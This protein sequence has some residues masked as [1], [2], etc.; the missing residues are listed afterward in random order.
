MSRLPP[1]RKA[2]LEGGMHS[3]KNLAECLAIDQAALAR[4]VLPD[5]GLEAALPDVLARLNEVAAKGISHQIAAIGMAI[6]IALQ[7][8]KKAA[9]RLT[10]QRLSN[11]PSDTVRSWAAFALTR[12]DPTIALSDRLAMARPFAA[13]THFGVR[14]W[15]W[16][17]VRPYIA[18]EIVPAVMLLQGWTAS[19]NPNIRRFAV[20]STRPRGVWG[21]HIG[22]LKTDP[23]MALPLL[24]ALKADTAR[25]VQDSVANWL[26]DASKT[27]PAW[28][29]ALCEQWKSA[30]NPATDRIVDRALRTVRKHGDGARQAKRSR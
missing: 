18:A 15:A 7:G 20:E 17:A 25:Y 5:I 30:A 4:A 14:E 1:E 13:D 6:G 26:N 24:E 22:Q 23:S 19:P 9:A 28:V 27:A 12:T 10:A 2:A 8:L 16:M 3:T 29:V 21:E 11:H